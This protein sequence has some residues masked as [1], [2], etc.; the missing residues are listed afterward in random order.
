M[1]ASSSYTIQ[2]NGKKADIAKATEVL[3]EKLNDP[4]LKAP[5]KKV[6]IA[7][8]RV[9]WWIEDIKRLAV[10]MAQAAPGLRFTVSGTVDSSGQFMDFSIT[11]D[12]KTVLSRESDWY[13]MLEANECDGYEDFAER[14]CSESG[15]PLYSEAE[16][17]EFCA[18]D[19]VFYILDSGHG[20][21]VTAV[22][23]KDAEDI[24]VK[25]G[26]ETCCACGVQRPVDEMHD[27]GDGFCF[28]KEC[29]KKMFG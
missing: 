9:C 12:G 21:I 20:D 29:Y 8:T 2:F 3:A 1:Q 24:S 5:C 27:D 22:P 14:L 10:K 18:N 23:L 15:E 11:C 4:S 25:E 13:L 7:E 26:Y 17:E 6:Q 16:F 28:C 19:D